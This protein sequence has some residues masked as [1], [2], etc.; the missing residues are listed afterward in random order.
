M[1][2]L[3]VTDWRLISLTLDSI[4]P[5]QSEK[6]FDFAGDT[7]SLEAKDD[8]PG[9]SSL[10]MI[11][12]KN[13]HGKTTILET[14]HGLF[15]LLSSPPTGRFVDYRA[16]GKAQLD[17]RATWTIDG[18]TQTVLLSIWTGNP[19]PLREWTD[20]ALEEEAQATGWARLG[21]LRTP[22]GITCYDAT[23]EL[24]FRLFSAIRE[25]AGRTLPSVFGESLYLPTV[26]FFPAD[27]MLVRP[28]DHRVIEAPSNW[29]YQPAH[30]FGVD[31]AT[32]NGSIDNL[33]AWLTWV[34]EGELDRLLRF[35]NENVFEANGKTLQPMERAELTTYVM[36][37][38]GPHPLSG[39]SHGERALLQLYLRLAAHMSRN[40]VLLIDEIEMHLHTG[41]MHKMFQTMKKLL[42][43][44]PSLSI[45]FTTHSREL[46]EVFDFQRPE[47]GIVKGGY[48]IEDGLD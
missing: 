5:F 6:I 37:A 17:V 4:G 7:P 42:A 43:E 48:V 1:S 16:P 26:L 32:W 27:R 33:F 22:D 36:T 15:G 34:D 41:W 25:A 47:S 11:L 29:V 8:A 46:A 38:D 9:P 30:C 44:I 31:G 28:Q 40:T 39:L 21:V 2:D 20:K 23:D 18:V 13:G 3:S 24:G 14:I 10:Y 19:T 45:V 12:A 35:V